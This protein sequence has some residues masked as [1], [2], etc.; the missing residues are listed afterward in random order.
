MNRALFLDRD[1]T[2]IE[3]PGYLRDPAQVR[4]LPGAVEALA[5]LAVEGWKLII[6]SNQSG[7]GRGWIA[8]EE[9]DAVHDRFLQLMRLHGVPITASYFCTHTPEACCSCRKPSAFF[10]EQAAREHDIDLKVSW[11]AGDREG[12]IRCGQ[13]AGCST[14]WLRND[15]FP[16]APD[17]PDFI[18]DDWEA[19]RRR[20]SSTMP[21]R[22]PGV[23]SGS[24]EAQPKRHLPHD[25]HQ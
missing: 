20:L 25:R 24:A 15:V 12:D 11:M 19:I 14:I 8:P 6:I 5:A 21:P 18:A 13:S 3:D 7:V 22:A 10:V 1:G 2:V 23:T 17:L 9:M 4:L 16:L